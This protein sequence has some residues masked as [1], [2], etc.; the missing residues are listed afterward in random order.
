MPSLT[1]RIKNWFSPKQ[2]VGDLEANL[3]EV[4]NA[5][6]QD[7]EAIPLDEEIIDLSLNQNNTPI[8]PS[9]WDTLSHFI[10]FI[11]TKENLPTITMVQI[12]NIVEVGGGI[13][14]P[15]LFAKTT[16]AAFN[17]SKSAKIG[18]TELSLNLLVSLLT[19]ASALTYVAGLQ[20]QKIL[21]RVKG[22]TYAEA[23]NKTTYRQLNQTAETAIK[24]GYYGLMEP[25]Q[26]SMSVADFGEKVSYQGSQALTATVIGSCIM[27][28][29]T[30]SPVLGIST[31]A[32]LAANAAWAAYRSSAVHEARTALTR[33]GNNVWGK[34]SG[35]LQ[36]INIINLY[37]Q[38]EKEMKE[39]SEATEAYKEALAKAEKVKQETNQ[40]H[41]LISRLSMLVAVLYASHKVTQNDY[42]A[43]DFITI[44]GYLAQVCDKS[45]VFG[46]AFLDMLAYL[47]DLIVVYKNWLDESTQIKDN[48]PDIA[49]N[50][51]DGGS[52]AIEFKEVGFGYP[53]SPGQEQAPAPILNGMSFKIEI[54]ERVAFVG[55]SGAGKSTIFKLLFGQYSPTKGSIEINGQNVEHLSLHSR[56]AHIN[57]FTQSAHLF[58]GTIRENILYGAQESIENEDETIM[59]L[60]QKVGLDNFLIQLGLDTQVGEGGGALSGGQQQKVALLRGLMKNPEG[61]LL[62][63]EITASLD[64]AAA[65]EIIKLLKEL[66]TPYASLMITHDL[67]RATEFATKLIVIDNGVVIA[68]GTHD[69]LVKDCVFYKDLWAAVKNETGATSSYASMSAL[70]GGIAS[71]EIL[72]MEES[73]PMVSDV[74]E[75]SSS[76]TL[77]DESILGNQDESSSP[78][79]S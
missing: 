49:L 2:P 1:Q 25:I 10:S 31:V 45:S 77:G 43:K 75:A 42:N 57:L 22:D 54:G 18:D 13:L 32:L 9:T 28:V 67:N 21:A 34:F 29:L 74:L 38:L 70:M 68:V 4:N 64:A 16:E 17:E 48:H 58:K 53:L 44:V 30:K 37:G 59:T 20:A 55:K 71:N 7:T 61:I 79:I 51:E 24:L 6:G 69:Q 33:T 15:I 8:T 35:K 11:T 39:V 78:S 66:P 62:F 23:V 19:T 14:T 46:A 73:P 60:A 26:K 27:T 52:S 12:L 3:A 5:P 63:D 72:S 65:E 41:V 40:G 47:P 50:L 76:K 36:K 56:Q